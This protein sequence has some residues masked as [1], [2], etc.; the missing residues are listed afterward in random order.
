MK[1]PKLALVSAIIILCIAFLLLLVPNFAVS[2][3][4]GQM[5]T[6]SDHVLR[7]KLEESIQLWT[8]YQIT[9]F[10]PLAIVSIVIA[11]V[12]FIYSLIRW[13]TLNY[14]IAT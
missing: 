9:V 14:P 8:I 1:L 10:Q 7:Y 11:I 13:I 3:I 6:T 2:M 5:E 12:L 4:R